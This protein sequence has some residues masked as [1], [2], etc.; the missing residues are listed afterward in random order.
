[1]RRKPGTNKEIV[2]ERGTRSERVRLN[3]KVYYEPVET[4][5]L[6]D[7]VP[8]LELFSENLRS[9]A[10]ATPKTSPV[11][12]A[13]TPSVYAGGEVQTSMVLSGPNTFTV[14]SVVKKIHIYRADSQV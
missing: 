8:E 1:M 10:P 13:R 7:G 14:M 11:A 6:I 3:V 2:Y 5:E 9:E 12:P 4:Q